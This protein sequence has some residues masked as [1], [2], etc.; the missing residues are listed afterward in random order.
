MLRRARIWMEGGLVGAFFGFTGILDA[1]AILAQALCLVCCF[2]FLLSLLFSLFEDSESEL[3]GETD[4]AHRA[5]PGFLL[6]PNLKRLLRPT[7]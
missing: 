4:M 5:R 7:E 2:F 6:A 3:R 1:T